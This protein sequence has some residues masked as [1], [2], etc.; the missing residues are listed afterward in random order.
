MI[1]RVRPW[2]FECFRHGVLS[3]AGT[4]N[5]DAGVGIGMKNLQKTYKNGPGDDQK[6]PNLIID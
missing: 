5:A 2:R 4:T 6:W 1:F 3:Q